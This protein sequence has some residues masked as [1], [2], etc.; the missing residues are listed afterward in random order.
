[1][2]PDIARKLRC[3]DAKRVAI[4]TGLRLAVA[5]VRQDRPAAPPGVGRMERQVRCVMAR[6]ATGGVVRL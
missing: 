3:K 1:M 6:A 5:T 2:R 4:A